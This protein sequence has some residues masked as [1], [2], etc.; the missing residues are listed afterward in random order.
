MG[1]VDVTRAGY[2][3]RLEI[4]LPF[5]GLNLWEPPRSTPWRCHR[6]LAILRYQED[7]FDNRTRTWVVGCKF[8]ASLHGMVQG[9]A[10]ETPNRA[11]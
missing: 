5:Q 2:I 3:P 8:Y 1:S 10:S 7:I 4:A 9:K 11:I 6:A